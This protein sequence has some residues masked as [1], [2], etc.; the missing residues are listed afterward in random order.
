MS[1]SLFLL[2]LPPMNLW[3]FFIYHLVFSVLSGFL[4]PFIYLSVFGN[5][6]LNNFHLMRVLAS[7]SSSFRT[8]EE[9]ILD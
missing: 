8:G 4:L 9:T 5:S 1:V 6:P 3:V 7:E 2:L